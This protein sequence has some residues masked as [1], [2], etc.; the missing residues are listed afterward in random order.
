MEQIAH[1][2]PGIMCIVQTNQATVQMEHKI[3]LIAQIFRGA[4]KQVIILIV[5]LLL[6]ELNV[7]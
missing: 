7:H 5:R 2:I 1:I 4:I 3:I 6:T